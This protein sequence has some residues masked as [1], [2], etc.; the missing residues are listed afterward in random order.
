MEW[1]EVKAKPVR[2]AKA[3]KTEEDDGYYGAATGNK[4]T[5]GPIK[6]ASY[7]KASANH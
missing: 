1:N 5:A 2:K 6:G 7:G 3:K 4:L